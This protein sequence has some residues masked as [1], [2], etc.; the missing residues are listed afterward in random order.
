[1]N[2]STCK[3]RSDVYFIISEVPDFIVICINQLSKSILKNGVLFFTDDIFDIFFTVFSCATK[4][5]DQIIRDMIH[6]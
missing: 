1:M 3:G 6:V 4:Y 2:V 5:W